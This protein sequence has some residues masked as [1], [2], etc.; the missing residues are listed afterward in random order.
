M[1]REQAGDLFL[2][3]AYYQETGELPEMD[4][5]TEIAIAPF[6]NQFE[7]DNAKYE[8]VVQ[9]NKSNGAKGGRRK[10]TQTNP[11]N[12][13]EP[14]GLFGNPEIPMG[15]DNVSVSDS[16]KDNKKKKGLSAEYVNKDFGDNI[17]NAAWKEWVIYRADIKKPLTDLAAKKCV[18]ELNKVPADIGKQ[19]IDTAIMNGWTGLFIP[20][21]YTPVIPINSQLGATGTTGRKNANSF[22]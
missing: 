6:I 21:N 7:R 19:M 9:R 15:A 2:A 13:K 1:T 3:I 18:D 12:P 10:E 22:I 16:K 14:T 17:L 11:E 5:L 8:T 4:L 20:K